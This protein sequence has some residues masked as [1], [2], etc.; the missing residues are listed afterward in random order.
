MLTTPRSHVGSTP[1]TD[2]RTSDHPTLAEVRVDQARALGI[3]R[4]GALLE[5]DLAAGEHVHAVAD[6]QREIDALL[7]DEQR[8]PLVAQLEQRL[9][10]RVD[11][12]RR[13]A[14]RRLVEQQ[15]LGVAHQHPA[16]RDH[17]LLAAAER[18]GRARSQLL[19][20]REQL[21]DRLAAAPRHGPGRGAGAAL[22]G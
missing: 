18:R 8:P 14:E 13:E 19:E 21:V 3:E 10:D 7:D 9:G 1:A 4:V 6:A 11:R 12:E 5:R 15:E 2:R 17:L 16:D 22:R 20:D